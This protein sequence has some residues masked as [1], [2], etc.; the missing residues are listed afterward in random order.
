M[1][2]KMVFF[3]SQLRDIDQMSDSVS[4]T[5][6]IAKEIQKYDSDV[7][8]EVKRGVKGAPKVNMKNYGNISDSYNSH[9]VSLSSMK[10]GDSSFVKKAKG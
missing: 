2:K 5:S 9:D 3:D 10:S 1:G 4:I 6:A 7:N 8:I